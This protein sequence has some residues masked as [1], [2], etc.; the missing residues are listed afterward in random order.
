MLLVVTN[1]WEVF[2]SPK[3]ESKH[4]P[5]ASPALYSSLLMALGGPRQLSANAMPHGDDEAK[6]NK[7]MFAPVFCL[8]SEEKR[9]EPQGDSL[10]GFSWP[11]RAARI[12]LEALL[13]CG[14]A[15]VYSDV[16]PQACQRGMFVSCRQVKL[17]RAS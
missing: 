3:A 2:P 9:R 5:K 8:Y 10:E 13:W 1:S 4:R 14:E 15:F 7:G 16:A 17:M 12:D 11:S 6:L